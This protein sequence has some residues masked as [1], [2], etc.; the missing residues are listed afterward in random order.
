MNAEFPPLTNPAEVH[1]L[2]AALGSSSPAERRAAAERLAGASERAVVEAL[3]RISNDPDLSVRYVARRSLKLVMERLGES[4]S[5][6]RIEHEM[7]QRTE[8]DP[9]KGLRE[10]E[11]LLDDADAKKRMS[12]L[13]LVSAKRLREALPLLLARLD[14]ETDP[15]IVATLVKLVGFLGDGAVLP[16]L[17]RFLRCEDPRVRANT[18]EGIAYVHD[19]AKV[20]ILE[21]LVEDPDHRIRCNALMALFTLRESFVID[22]LRRMLASEIEAVRDSARSVI[23]RL[24]ATHRVNLTARLASPSAVEPVPLRPAPAA[25]GGARP[26]ETAAAPSTRDLYLAD[27]TSILLAQPRVDVGFQG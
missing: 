17:S 25:P 9:G 18:V 10:I 1:T 27:I 23:S 11:L 16:V 24:E 6:Q 22:H 2:I 3:K 21:P 13:K 19:N 20:S 8:A 12:A 5:D 14:V 4:L 15:F 7:G 26:E